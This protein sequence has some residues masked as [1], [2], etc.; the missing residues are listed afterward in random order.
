MKCLAQ[1][2]NTVSLEPAISRSQNEH[3][4]TKQLC[5]IKSLHILFYYDKLWVA[6]SLIISH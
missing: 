5:F 3:P 1:G 4:I 2:H 6:F